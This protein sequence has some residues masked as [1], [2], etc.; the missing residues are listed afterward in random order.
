VLL[1]PY[2]REGRIEAI[3]GD[4]ATVLVG[5]A[6][7]RVRR[8]DCQRPE[9]GEPLEAPRW[10]TAAAVSRAEALEKQT[11]AREINLIGFTVE[12]GTERLDKFLDE[13]FVAGHPEVRVV[14][15]HGTGRLRHAIRELMSRHPHVASHRPGSPGEGGDG[16]TIALLG[17][18]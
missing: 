3:D 7:F 16:A 4:L 12:E 8:E 14:H 17:T 10:R 13:A 11:I 5:S 18:S 1:G 15:G 2:G 9:G 6:R